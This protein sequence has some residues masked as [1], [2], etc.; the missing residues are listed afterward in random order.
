MKYKSALYWFTNDLRLSDN[1]L[2]VDM[3]NQA[4][5]VG[6]VY[7]I[8][9]GSKTHNRFQAEAIGEHRYNFT[10]QSLQ[11]ISEELASLGHEL[12]VFKGDTNS[13]LQ[14]LF[15]A[16][17]PN[18]LFCSKPFGYNERSRLTTLIKDNPSVSFVQKNQ[19]TL[20]NFE[21]ELEKTNIF[22]SF[23]KFRKYVEH[24][25]LQ[26]QPLSLLNQPL[27]LPNSLEVD[28]STLNSNI[29]TESLLPNEELIS[30]NIKKGLFYGGELSALSHISDYFNSGAPRRYKKTRND[31]DSWSS[32]TK[33]SP[34]LANGC[35]SP[36]SLWHRVE[37]Y[38]TE[39]ERNE[40][41]Y[42]IKFELLWRE[43]FQWLSIK[44]G[45]QLFHFSGLANTAPLTSFYP[46]RLQKWKAGMTPYPI[47]NACMKQ[48]NETGYMSNRG[49]QLVAS[50]LV[51]ELAL[52][53]R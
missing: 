38:E 22:S 48:L 47:V 11:N 13:I 43:Y 36:V 9:A 45:Y 51:H 2:L 44:I 15:Y 8:D 7:I 32:S 4:E 16:I 5:N 19:F 50:C 34:Y 37:Q 10:L 23:S 25:Q 49:R 14:Q 53:W 28:L 20:F 26:P 18:A 30:R 42:W 3:I 41:T 1:T 52:D 21:R 17:K 31:L 46:N 27:R 33:F 40:S 29:L 6:F 24:G 39:V 35:V 12:L